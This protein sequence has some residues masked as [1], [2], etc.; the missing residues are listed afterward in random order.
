MDSSIPGDILL[1]SSSDGL[2]VLFGNTAMGSF[3][4]GLRALFCESKELTQQIQAEVV[5]LAKAG[6]NVSE[7][8]FRGLRLEIK[9]EMRRCGIAEIGRYSMSSRALEKMKLPANDDIEVLRAAF[10]SLGKEG[11]V[12]QIISSDEVYT[13]RG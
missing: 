9:I 2:K 13:Y 11:R 3:L 5:D 10:Q 6:F 12:A 7:Q 4:S 1:K 8:D